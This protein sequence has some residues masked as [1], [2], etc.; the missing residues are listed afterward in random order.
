MDI[1]R[2]ARALLMAVALGTCPLAL[3]Q[4]IYAE[5]YSTTAG[6]TALPG[7]PSKALG[8]PGLPSGSDLFIT[9]ND[10]STVRVFADNPGT[11]DIGVITLRANPN[12]IPTLIVGKAQNPQTSTSAAVGTLACRNLGGINANERTRA[13]IHAT[14]ISGPG[15][16]VHQLVRLDLTGDLNAPVIHWG[17]KGDVAIG[18]IAIGRSITPEGSV[19]AYRGAIGPIAIAGDLNGHL[20]ARTGAIASIEVGGDMGSAGR[21]AVYATAPFNA[22]AIASLDV[23]GDI[24]RPGAHADIITAGA[25]R[26]I[27][28][29]AIYATIDLESDPAIAGFLAGVTARTG[30]L[31]G[32]LRAR[33]LTS[34]GGL[35]TAPCFVSI[36]GDLDGDIVFTNVVRNERAGGPEIDIA[37]GILEGSN[38][39]VG[40]M[41]ITNASMPAAE[42]RVRAE[43]GLAGHIIVGKGL[44]TD[45]PEPASVRVGSASPSTVTSSSKFYTA[46]FASFGGGSVAIAPFNFH[47]NESF[48]KHNAVVQLASN[49]LLVAVA[50]RFFG[51]VFTDTLAEMI[52]EHQA[53]ASQVWVDRSAEF[54]TEASTS[55][56]GDRTIV[57]RAIVPTSFGPGTWRLRPVDG[58]LR[59]ARAIGAPDVRFVSEYEDDTYRFS[60]AGGSNCPQPPGIGRTSDSRIDFDDSDGIIRAVCP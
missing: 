37:G 7:F 34:F 36:A 42:I 15:V 45:F 59:S 5:R 6:W 4:G 56:E 30:G 53:P 26:T 35:G 13:Q 55:E 22:F 2:P 18:G 44:D 27:E 47:Q 9:V 8:Q 51:P 38:I 3:A 32:L 43:Q 41:P 54:T 17:D 16:E 12:H 48:P 21:P 14:S 57:V 49:E 19:V 10:S 46:P 1:H 29:D 33:S 23:G 52:V 11:T 24:G 40:A 50:P 39:V 58:T 60:V 31:T 20:I 28:A 25:V